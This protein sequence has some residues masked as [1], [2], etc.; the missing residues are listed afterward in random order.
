V[1]LLTVCRICGAASITQFRKLFYVLQHIILIKVLNIN[2]EYKIIHLNNSIIYIIYVK[3]S[4]KIV[5]W[6]VF[7]DMR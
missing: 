4:Y 3:E 2:N 6:H 7:L 1:D 5:M